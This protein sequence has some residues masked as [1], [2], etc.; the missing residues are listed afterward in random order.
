LRTN[1]TFLGEMRNLRSL[2]QTLLIFSLLLVRIQASNLTICFSTNELN[3][4]GTTVAIYDYAH[5]N[6]KLLDNKSLFVLPAVEAVTRG[7][8][9]PRFKAR[10][11]TPYYYDTNIRFSLTDK[12]MSLSCDVLYVIKAGGFD[13]KP[14]LDF[15][16][17]CNGPPVA[18]HAVFF[19]QK[20][21]AAYSMISED[22][23]IQ[24]A[25]K[26]LREGVTT[27]ESRSLIRDSWV[28]HIIEAPKD[29]VVRTAL[30]K[31]NYRQELRIPK[32]ALV[33]CRHGSSDTFN[34]KFVHEA[35]CEAARKHFGAIY[36]LFLGTNS[37]TCA[38]S[39]QNIYFLP[40]TTDVHEKEAYFNTCD[41]MLHARSEGEQFSVALGE[42]SVRNLPI[43]F[44]K[45]SG[46]PTQPIE[47]HEKALLYT[48]KQDLLKNIAD[49]TRNGVPSGDYNAYKD[50]S[51][52]A[53]M[54]RFNRILIQR[55]LA[56]KGKMDDLSSSSSSALAPT[57][58]ARNRLCTPR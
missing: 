48:N 15:Q 21:G 37:W 1:R 44:R 43:L 12:A 23:A 56:A 52:L 29:D 49:M 9:M 11:G 36:F 32:K 2:F 30:I 45:T 40:K 51:P 28:P 39:Q 33:L 14:S 7:A 27:K 58:K 5:Y 16:I 42:A 31:H 20:H 3:E 24:R 53:V 55:A 35:V 34:V 19:W 8:S 46:N 41:A 25:A 22:Q 47:T 18:I 26:Q 17:A 13:S 38:D 54:E 6:E 57:R 50:F 10:F 4:R